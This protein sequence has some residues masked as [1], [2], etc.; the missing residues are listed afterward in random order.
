[1]SMSAHT[2][3]QMSAFAQSLLEQNQNGT[4]HSVYRNTVNIQTEHMLL[5]LQTA[6]SVLSPVSLIT[7][8]DG[9]SMDALR[10]SPGLPVEISGGSVRLGPHH[11]DYSMSGIRTLKTDLIPEPEKCSLLCGRIAHVLDSVRT[12]GFDIIFRQRRGQNADGFSLVHQTAMQRMEACRNSL[13]C[14]S[15]AEA[16]ASLV[17]LIGLGSGLTPSGDD[18]LCGVLAGIAMTGA[19][20]HPFSRCLTEEIRAHLCGTN[21]ISRTFLLC[22]LEGQFSAPVCDLCSMPSAAQIAHSFG[23]IGHSS[24]IDTLCGIFYTIAHSN[25]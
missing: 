12:N 14:G 9:A 1:M 18:F 4:V 16:A 17:R 25:A 8:L 11:F 23:Q 3:T 7:G 5:A 13:L 22:A 19:E 6:H 24:G 15:Y 21:D 20:A 2:I 10:L